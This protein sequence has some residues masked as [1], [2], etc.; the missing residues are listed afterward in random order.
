MILKRRKLGNTSI[1]LTSLG[2]GGTGIGNLYRRVSEDAAA[3]TMNAA[4][5][6][7]IRYFD[8]APLYGHGLSEHRIGAD[9]RRF[10]TQDIVLS[11]KVG[12][13]LVPA[14]GRETGAGHFIDAPPFCRIEDY[15]YDGVMR[16]FEDSLQRLG[17][18]RIPILFLHDVDRRNMGERYRE[19]FRT[20]MAGAYKAMLSLRE[21]RA[22]DAIGVGVNEWQACEDFVRAGDF[23]GCLLAGRYTLL[24]Q[25]SLD[26]LLPLCKQRGVGIVLGGP[27]NSGILA[28]GALDG[29]FYNYTP[30]SPEIMRRVQCLEAVCKRYGVPL[31]AVALQ[32]PLHHPVITSVIPG[33]GDPAEVEENVRL[34]HIDIPLDLW[35]EM[36]AENLIRSDAEISVL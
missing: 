23:N 16:S 6:A 4:Y 20:A 36:K 26:S 9:L 13:R 7:G 31:K 15:S 29:A 33:V 1:E 8:T 11:S 22:V 30:A 32:F 35:Q 2:F 17:V 5:I 19:V 18:D 10:P 28:T 25:E 21:Q 3:A 27:Y 34:L 14:R 24:D 12:W